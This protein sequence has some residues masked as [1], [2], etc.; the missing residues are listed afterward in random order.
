MNTVKIYFIN[1]KFIDPDNPDLFA[2]V[3]LEH[4][5][6]H[7]S[8]VKNRPRKI[9]LI[10]S[11]LLLQNCLGFQSDEDFSLGKDGQL[12]KRDG[13]TNFC[14]SHARDYTI[15]AISED[16]SPLGADIEEFMSGTDEKNLRHRELIAKKVMP[17][18][19]LQKYYDSRE[20]DEEIAIFAQLWTRVEAV[21]KAEGTG[22]SKDPLKHPE[23]F[24][25]W[26]VQYASL[27]EHM[28]CIAQ[29]DLNFT[30]ELIEINPHDKA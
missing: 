19:L 1:H 7:F 18:A 3:T 24:D 15:L 30:T 29:K 27:P 16:S 13:T 5:K 26:K 9:E 28:I 6:N 17:P 10:C 11:A 14:L 4:Y 23:L 25:L 12:Q 22:F 2:R 20:T 21:L 8:T